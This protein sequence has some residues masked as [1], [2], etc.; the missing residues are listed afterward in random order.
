MRFSISALSEAPRSRENCVNKGVALIISENF[1]PEHAFPLTNIGGV[2]LNSVGAAVWIITLL[3]AVYFRVIMIC[4]RICT[5]EAD[6]SS[7]EF[8]MTR[9]LFTW[10]GNRHVV[11]QGRV[12]V[13]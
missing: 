12:R 2:S 3:H 11:M 1:L 4:G 5:M 13:W 10:C 9:C 6:E 7:G 8:K